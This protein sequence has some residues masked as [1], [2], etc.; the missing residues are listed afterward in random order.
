MS[1]G[2]NKGLSL[3]SCKSLQGEF[4]INENELLEVRVGAFDAGEKPVS[5]WHISGRR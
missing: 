1:L 4:V 5:R 3:G 2:E